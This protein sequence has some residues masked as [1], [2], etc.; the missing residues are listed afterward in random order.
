MV[1][2]FLWVPGCAEQLL[3]DLTLVCPALTPELAPLWGAG[4][5]N[6]E[7]AEVSLGCRYRRS[8]AGC[9]DLYMFM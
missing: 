4:Y 8:T 1:D 3:S 7:S 9:F 6:L 2:L 5:V